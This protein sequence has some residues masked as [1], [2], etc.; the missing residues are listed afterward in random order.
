MVFPFPFSVG[1]QL[2]VLLIFQNESF[3]PPFLS[4]LTSLVGFSLSLRIIDS[5]KKYLWLTYSVT[6]I[7]H[8]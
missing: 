7:G 3:V 5:F 8:H 1:F 4:N 6:G 2:L